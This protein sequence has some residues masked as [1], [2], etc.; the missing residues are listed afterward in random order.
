MWYVA[1]ALCALDRMT[2]NAT[3]TKAQR[4]AATP[5]DLATAVDVLP[6]C[7]LVPR[8]YGGAVDRQRL[9]WPAAARAGAEN[10]VDK[11]TTTSLG[12]R[13]GTSIIRGWW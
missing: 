5:T 2:P 8:G 10:S 3:T 12:M 9:P 4:A 13:S 7:G 11:G 1:Q 6:A